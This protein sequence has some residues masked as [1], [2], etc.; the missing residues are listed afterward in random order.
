MNA[1]DAAHARE[2]MARARRAI[3]AARLLCAS[4]QPEAAVSRAYYAA[5]Y[6]ACALVATKGLSSRKHRG[7]IG[8]FDREFV[9]PGLVDP[10][11]G[12]ALHQL[13]HERGIA[14]YGSFVEFD[15]DAVEELV[16]SAG[17]LIEAAQQ[18]LPSLLQ[19]E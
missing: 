3:E 14:D 4:D 5:F 17:D 7:L 19:D 13:F 10:K 8:M 6:A 11:H 9:L 12:S 2:R 15:E 18:L 1:D 16:N